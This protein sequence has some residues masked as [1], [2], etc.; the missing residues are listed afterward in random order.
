MDC[1]L[2]LHIAYVR[3]PYQIYN[4]NNVHDMRQ[5][6]QCSYLVLNVVF[7]NSYSMVTRLVQ[8]THRLVNLYIRS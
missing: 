4:V 1:R 8:L 7:S 5:N 2:T 6:L 3:I